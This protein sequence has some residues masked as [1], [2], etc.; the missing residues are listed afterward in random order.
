MVPLSGE[1]EAANLAIL[2]H[3]PDGEYVWSTEEPTS[4]YR[5]VGKNRGPAS[6]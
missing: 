5:R 2:N 4:I 6:D 3:Q 1:D